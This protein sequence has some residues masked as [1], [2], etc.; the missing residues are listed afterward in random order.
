MWCAGCG[1]GIVLGALARAFSDLDLDPSQI[2]VVTGIGCWGKADDYLRTNA[3]HGT[4]GR[5]LAFA[6]GVKGA[7]PSLQVVALM[8]DGDGVT[9][10]GNHLIHA[11]RRN[12]SIT[13]LMVNNYNYGMTGGQYSATTPYGG[14]TTTSR[15]G[16][17]EEAFDTCALVA[18]AGAA[19]VAR[20]SAYQPAQLRALLRQALT[21]P[22]FSF[23]E[24]ASTC[25]TY[26]GR[27]NQA[28]GPAEQLK[29]VAASV[30]S[31]GIVAKRQVDDFHARYWRIHGKG[32]E[33]ER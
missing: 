29:D 2:V 22:G 3:L 33:H 20:T 5:A 27:F 1:H 30:G 7:R 23:V 28:P 16:C 15:E 19:L 6:T 8:G 9:I 17:P 11:A 26:F 31:P 25:P 13:G 4:H 10:G 12:L 21:T 32:D 18:A 24:V 14:L